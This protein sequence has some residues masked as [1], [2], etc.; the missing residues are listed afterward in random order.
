MLELEEIVDFIDIEKNHLNILVIEDEIIVAMNIRQ[1]LEKQGYGKIEIFNNAQ[2]ALHNLAE[3][4]Y[5]L[6][7]IDINIKGEL[8]GID[9]A[10]RINQFYKIPV[11]YLTAYS[12]NETL[13]RA[14]ET[15]PY[16][17]IVKPFEVEQ[18]KSSVEMALYKFQFESRLNAS[19]AKFK[20][21]FEFASDGILICD[22]D[23][24][25]IIEANQTIQEILGYELDELLGLNWINLCASYQKSGEDSF[26]LCLQYQKQVLAGENVN[27]EWIFVKKNGEKVYTRL[28]LSR[29]PVDNKNWIRASI[30][31]ITEQKKMEKEF[32]HSEIRYRDLFNGIKSGVAV[33]EAINDGTDFIFKDINLAVENIEQL[34]RESIIGQSVL[35]VFPGIVD[36]GL[37]EIFQYVYKTGIPRELPVK[38]YQDS[39]IQGWRQNYV[40][41]LPSGEIVALYD[42]LT[43]IMRMQENLKNSNHKLLSIFESVGV[44]VIYIDQ[45]GTVLDINQQLTEIFEIPK[46]DIIGN[47]INSLA[48][49]YL[50]QL[51]MVELQ[52]LL[53]LL[54][55]NKHLP[56]FEMGYRSKI[57]EISAYKSH[58]LP[59]FTIIIRDITDIKQTMQEKQYLEKRLQQ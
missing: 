23:K 14:G 30:T 2:D 15:Q 42:D 3:N 45:T 41:K 56:P 11:I 29:I 10:E 58:G 48:E 22:I 53:K 34:S 32:Q 55:N 9:L 40:Y 57:L 52:K 43:E 46:E 4:R 35:Q 18:L 25:E 38:Y 19:E 13:K 1:F 17:Y 39:R 7:I 31:D 8:N 33:F 26:S 24:K 6:A 50:D 49:K 59:N 36:F 44:G 47:Q 12:D 54:L 5:Q 21:F 28:N 16:G 20:T 27:S 51:K 37:F